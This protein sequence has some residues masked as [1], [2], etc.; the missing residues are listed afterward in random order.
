[1]EYSDDDGIWYVDEMD[2]CANCD[3]WGFVI[4]LENP[5]E[6]AWDSPRDCEYCGGLGF[7]DK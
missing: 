7:V 3:G 1:M 2:V 5:W 4:E 6:E